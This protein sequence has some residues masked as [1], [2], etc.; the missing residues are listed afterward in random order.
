MYG[1]PSKVL[2]KTLGLI[3]GPETTS[4][5]RTKAGAGGFGSELDA[6]RGA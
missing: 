6:S 3:A 1:R 2:P 5:G 4:T